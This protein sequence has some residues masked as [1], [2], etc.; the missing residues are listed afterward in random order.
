[1]E[2]SGSCLCRKVRFTT[3]G[4]PFTYTVCHCTNCKKFS[5]SAFMSNAFFNSAK[6]TVTAGSD[7]VREYNDSATT[8]GNALTRSFCAECGSSLFLAPT[9]NKTLVI[10]CASAM[11]DAHEW[12]PRREV[13]PE[14]KWDWVKELEIHNPKKS[15]L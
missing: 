14:R 7:L 5:G 11:D 8:S 3:I 10:I 13:H 2:R 4:E 6:V 12:V 9:T 1:M 15:K